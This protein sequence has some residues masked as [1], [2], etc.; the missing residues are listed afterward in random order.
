M[1]AGTE[2]APGALLVARL[3]GAALLVAMAAIHLWLWFQGYAEI[4][5]VG[6]AFMVD[7]VAGT[8]LG[9]ALLAVPLR[10]VAAVALLGAVVVAGTLGALLLSLTVGLFGFFDT[11]DAPLVPTTLVVE[12]LGVIVLLATAGLAVVRARRGQG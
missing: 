12:V 8:V 5:L 3:A 10:V 9:V 6:P 11:I 1:P 4:D 7:A 2:T